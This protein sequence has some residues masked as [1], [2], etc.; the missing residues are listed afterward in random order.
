MTGLLM[1]VSQVNMGHVWGL[2]QYLPLVTELILPHVI[3]LTRASQGFM[4][5]FLSL[6]LVS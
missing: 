2:V 6:I 3:F 1:T 5:F 4:E